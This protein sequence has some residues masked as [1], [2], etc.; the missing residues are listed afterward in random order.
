MYIVNTTKRKQTHRY[1][2]L[3]SVYRWEAEGGGEMSVGDEKV[4]T[5]MYKI[6][7]L[8]GYTV[9]HKE[10][11]QLTISGVYLL[12]IMNPYIVYL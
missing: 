10:Y 8:Q 5:I 2:E 11:S 12:N 3:T 9:Q 4:Q 1:K 7:K 6:N